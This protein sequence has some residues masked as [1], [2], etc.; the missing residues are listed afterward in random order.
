MKYSFLLKK[1]EDQAIVFVNALILGLT[2]IGHAQS[3]KILRVNIH[4]TGNNRR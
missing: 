3:G 4:K 2:S 1:Q